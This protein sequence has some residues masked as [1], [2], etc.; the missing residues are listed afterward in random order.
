[1]I[2]KSSIVNSGGGKIVAVTVAGFD[3]SG[4]A[5]ILTDAK[6]LAQCGIYA[7]A[8]IT[9]LTVQSTLGVRRVE[10]VSGRTVRE[11]LECLAEDVELAG[12]KIGMLA[13]AEGVRAVAG[14][15]REA[16]M[17][18]ERVVLDPV[19]RSS[20][21]KALLDE[22]GVA[23]MRRELLPLVGWV[24]PNVDEL[25][26]LAG[27]PAGAR[28]D[29]PRL[30]LAVQTQAAGGLASQPGAGGL[31]VVVTGGHLEPPDDFLLTA[32]GEKQW[33]T[34]ARVETQS[35]HGTGCAFSSALLGRVLAGD[36]PVEAVAGARALVRQALER[37]VMVGRGR[38]PVV[39]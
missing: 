31:H 29:V 18:R 8:A 28:E 22:E 12:M 5:G 4:G 33:F 30:A 14:F 39:V 16:A 13:T 34:G 38:G 3:P 20:S 9:A 7:V 6:V 19:V 27:E 10:P 2:R 11:T 24:T 26:V 32:A 35:T 36:G 21:G 15:L 1:M 37:A 25:G 23:A 17:R